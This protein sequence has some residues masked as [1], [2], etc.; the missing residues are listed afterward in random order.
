MLEKS[1]KTNRSRRG[2][3]AVLT[4]V[5]LVMMLGMIALAVDVGYLSVA[6]TQL[7][8][9]ADAA[10]LAAAAVSNSDRATVQGVAQTYA[11]Y[12]Q[13]A[14]RP[15]QLNPN[16]VEFGL[17]D[18][19]TAT[20]TPSA[21]IN[22]A[23]RVTVRTDANSGGATPLFFARIFGRTSQDQSASAIA[24][25]NPRDI[26][27]VVDL[28][29]SMNFDTN[30]SESSS[31]ENLIQNIYDD[32]GFGEYPGAS[33]HAG[34]P[35]LEN[36]TSSWVTKLTESGGPL[37][38]ASVPE[39]YRV[40]SDWDSNK[41]WKAYAWVMEVQFA[42]LMPNVVPTPNASVSGNY[43]YWRSYIDSYRRNL[44]Y[45]SYVTL[46]M[47]EARDGT[48][49]GY[50]TPLSLRSE[51]A[52]CPMHPE[53]IRGESFSFPP[54]E[55][56]THAAR[57]AMIA[58]IQVI[59]DRNAS[60]ND[61][62]QKDWV[63]IVTFNSS[64][65]DEVKW[66][67][68]NRDNYAGAMNTCTLFQAYGGTGTEGGLNRAYNHI[69]AVSEGGLGRE[70]ANKIIVLLT[71]GMPNQK[72]SSLSSTTINNYKNSHPSTWTNPDTGQTVNNWFTGGDYY[73]EKNAA[74]MHT[75]S[76]QSGHWYVYAA[77]I[78]QGCDYDFMDRVARMGATSNNDGQCPRGSADPMVYENVLR[79][80]FENIITN[81]KLRLVK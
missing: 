46:M 19:A 17:W 73:V 10:A 51:L 16:D 66:S 4:A 41:T 48:V 65:T 39:R 42:S 43:N 60:I 47:D 71:D 61:V 25:V 1:S 13:V 27:F 81:P 9:A 75:S 55:M 52:P 20:F 70:N 59:R 8:A 35:L 64:S 62:N 57:R 23:V 69:K 58:A 76:M 21:S 5:M 7:Q 63:S 33:Q 24:T 30:P 36:S 26:C 14:G 11:S 15:V 45:L 56:P 37:R 12:N 28:S 32:F 50:H 18:A 80:I 40:T 29:R 6:R 74:L 2:A 68:S 44:G 53:L 49:A 38:Q 72:R 54:R 78:G 34:Y 31:T 77:G 67:L 3:I 79:Q 22:S